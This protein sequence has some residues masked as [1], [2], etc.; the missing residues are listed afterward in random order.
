MVA[1]FRGELFWPFR[2]APRRRS[3]QRSWLRRDIPDKLLRDFFL[4]F[5]PISL[6]AQRNGGKTAKE[7]PSNPC[8]L[9]PQTLSPYIRG[10]KCTTGKK[11]FLMPTA[12]VQA[13]GGFLFR[14]FARPVCFFKNECRGDPMWSPVFVG[15]VVLDV[16]IE[17]P[18]FRHFLWKCHLPW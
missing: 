17:F 8:S 5:T 16:P 7:T 9:L 6:T 10:L 3:C 13:D 14:F 2:K 1:R 4:I 11:C 15:N 12:I 18:P